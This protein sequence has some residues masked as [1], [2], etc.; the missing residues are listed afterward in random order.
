MPRKARQKSSTGIYH[1]VIKGCQGRGLFLDDAD[2]KVFLDEMAYQKGA[3]GL[4]IYAY[5]L[6]SNH[7]H[8]LLKVDDFSLAR[9]MQELQ[10]KYA[11]AFNSKY[12]NST[13]LMQNRFWSEPVENDARFIAVLRYIHQNPERSGLKRFEWTSF[14]AYECGKST[15][16]VDVNFAQSLFSST[17]DLISVLKS[18][19]R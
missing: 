1:V 18:P 3:S 6:M 15:E 9:C 16:T 14:S 4:A 2:R 7:V 10:R 17:D 5:C 12:D 19:L 13:R 11:R 8:I